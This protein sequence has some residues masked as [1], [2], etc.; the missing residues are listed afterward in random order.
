MKTIHAIY[1]KG[2]FRPTE[3]VDFPEN[4]A[5]EFETR[6]DEAIP[7]LI[8]KVAETDP[9]LAAIYEVLSRRHSS[10]H[11]DTAERHNEHQ[12]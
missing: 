9:G 5:V 7:D 4:A 12:P 3:A 1:E 8:K 10:G 6:L 11:T 2:V